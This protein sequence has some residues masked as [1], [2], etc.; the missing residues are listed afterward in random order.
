MLRKV[1]RR[2]PGR[3]VGFAV[4]LA[5]VVGCA[6][7]PTA[8][9]HD[10][11]EPRDDVPA[12]AVRLTCT[13][14]VRAGSME[15]DPSSHSGANGPSMNLIV[16][17]QHRFVR[18]ATTAAPE[19]DGP[20]WNAN[21]T[22]Q[23]LT[24]QP[25][26]T[27]DGTSPDPEGVRVFFM[28]EPSNGVTISNHDGADTFLGSGLQKYYA[29]AGSLLGPDGILSQGEVSS[30]K[31][32]RFELNGATEF[33]FSVLISTTVPDPG[34]YGV[35]LTRVVGGAYHT[36]GDGSDGRVY[37]WGQNN[38]GQVGDGTTSNRYTPVAVVAPGGIALSGVSSHGNAMHTC[39]IG[40]DAGVYCWGQ[41]DKGQL[42]DGTTTMRTAPVVV[43][44]PPG[45]TFSGVSAGGSHTCAHGS[46]GE[47]YCWG[48]NGYG[49]VGSGSTSVTAPVTRVD[50]P[51]GVEFSGV[52][53]GFLHTCARG[54]DSKVYC[55]GS[56]TGGALGL[57]STTPD[58]SPT[59]VPVDLPAVNVLGVAAGSQVGCVATD[60]GVYC[61]GSGSVGQ[62]GDGMKR[63]Q[64]APVL[65]AGTRGP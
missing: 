56:N 2:R 42:G 55:W 27:L 28:D 44:A 11:E 5:L 63:N 40:A 34:A 48:Y 24:L 15:C 54:S 10:G 12:F 20:Y 8:P 49:Q 16:G 57:G 4:A 47:L 19:F 21:V 39:A 52:A 31:P 9:L 7:E 51:T 62:L 29:Y 60:A 6:D 36:C 61:W 32:W 59:P 65:V 38:F 26:A 22:V 64:A 14:D 17:S 58:R 3:G 25:M 37:C 13:V 43:P 35:H 45:V 23:N 18:M 50:A 53:A 1:E 30:P 41:N 46:D 33:R